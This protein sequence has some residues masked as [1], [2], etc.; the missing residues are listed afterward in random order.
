MS[1]GPR[2]D[3][4]DRFHVLASRLRR[5]WRSARGRPTTVV[6]AVISLVAVVLTSSTVLS[7]VQL[8]GPS[9]SQPSPFTFSR[10]QDVSDNEVFFKTNYEWGHSAT[11]EEETEFRLKAWNDLEME[12]EYEKRTTAPDLEAFLKWKVEIEIESEILL[13]YD[14][15]GDGGFDEGVDSVVQEKHLTF[16]AIQWSI[17]TDR[18][19]S[20]F[21]VRDQDGFLQAMVVIFNGL[22]EGDGSSE[23]EPY[24]TFSVLISPWCVEG[25]THLA[26]LVKARFLHPDADRRMNEY[27]VSPCA[28]G[29]QLSWSFP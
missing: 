10:Q 27:V 29:M 18:K 19:K 2:V 24:G 15:D 17:D 20:S 28:D 9:S 6:A 7:S 23:N 21:F 4:R 14:A 16:E 22:L 11:F 25:S 1:R 12:V 5:L 13:F 3:A 26:I 8:M